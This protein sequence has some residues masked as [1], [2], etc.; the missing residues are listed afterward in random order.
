MVNIKKKVAVKARKG[1]K[2]LG[3]IAVAAI[4]ILG[5]IEISYR[6]T[7]SV[8]LDGEVIGYTND[9]VALQKRINDYLNSGNGKD[10]AFVE[11]PTMPTYE[12]VLLKKNVEANDDEIFK[13]IASKGTAYYRYYAIVADGT[14]KAYVATFEE[15]EQAVQKLKDKNS[16][17]KDK[18]GIVEKYNSK[19]VTETRIAVNDE[20]QVEDVN[21]EELT[22]EDKTGSSEVKLASVD[23]AVDKTYVKKVTKNYTSYQYIGTQIYSSTQYATSLGITLIQP[24]SGVITS[25]FGWRSRDNH[26]GLDIGT[27]TGTAIKAA[28]SGTVTLASWYYGYG[29]CVD[30][31]SDQ[32][33]AVSTRY[34]HCS[35]L[36][37]TPGQHVEQGQVI[38]A[39]GSTGISTGPH[40]H[41]EVSINGNRTDPQNYIYK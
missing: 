18:L 9:R 35:K 13:K 12:A 10:I 31:K 33:G 2:F 8:S 5:L 24:V 27:S 25:R 14:E 6:Q 7:Y 23:E 3:V 22:D 4:L 16:S 39:V 1:I 40:L 11:L 21:E 15:A 36:Y 17:N 28:H 29:N 38:A 41:F 20:G 37:V 34:G 26:K 19:P 32:N 30:I